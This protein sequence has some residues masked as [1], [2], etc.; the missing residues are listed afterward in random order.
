MLTLS[1]QVELSLACPQPELVAWL[2]KN[3]ILPQAYSPLGSTGASQRDNEVIDK[4]AKKHGVDGANIL[5]SWSVKR[6]CNPLP[7]SV[8]PSRIE[9]NQKR[10]CSVLRSVLTN[11]RRPFRRGVPGD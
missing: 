10:E 9:N 1:D 11:S 2:K 7:K 8:T 6:G 5:L 4:I 3:D